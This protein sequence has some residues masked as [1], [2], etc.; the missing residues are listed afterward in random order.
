MAEY[1]MEIEDNED[2]INNEI[3]IH[4]Q[5]N[6]GESINYNDGLKTYRLND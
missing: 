4:M 1:N 3:Y 5:L 2:Q 6:I